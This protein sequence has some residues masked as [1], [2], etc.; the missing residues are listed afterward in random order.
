MS[1]KRINQ[2]GYFKQMEGAPDIKPSEEAENKVD[3]TFKV[4]EQ[5]R[6]Q[7]TFGGG[8]S[9][10]E[11]AF[12]N[13]SFSTTNF[14]G[15]GET[16]TVA[17]QSGS[18]TRNYRSA[19]ASRTSSIGR[20]RPASTSSSTGPPICRTARPSATASR[21]RGSRSPPGSPLAASRASS[22]SYTFQVVDIY[23]VDAGDI[24]GGTSSIYANGSSLATSTPRTSAAPAAARR[25]GSAPRSCATPSTTPTSLAAARATPPA[26]DRGRPAA[27]QRRLPQAERGA[28][29]LPAGGPPHGTRGARR[30]R[31]TSRASAAPR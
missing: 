31:A 27:G 24:A 29:A 20:S 9:G 4:E 11:G 23:D 6:N 25:A 13:A 18:R 30:G 10:Y 8:F 5:N 7:F 21:A 17:A 19:S 14:L 26:S 12:L 16:V 3:V 28:R 15:A 2:L 22:P 1:I